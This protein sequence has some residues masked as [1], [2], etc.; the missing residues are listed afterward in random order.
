M[1]S[2]LLWKSVIIVLALCG[3][4]MPCQAEK[5]SAS[6]TQGE[7]QIMTY[8]SNN[9]DAAK[10]S[11][12]KNK[13][14]FVEKRVLK[15]GMTVLVRKTDQVP[16]VSIQ[17]WYHVGS[18]DEKTGERGI[19][20]LIEHMMFKGTEEL[21]ESDINI[22]THR[23]SGSTNAFTS[24]DY[25]GYLFN[26]PTQHWREALPVMADT[27]QHAAFKD[28]HLNSEMKAVIQELKMNRDNYVRSLVSELM[29][30]IFPDHPYHYPVIGYKQDLWSVCSSDLRAFYKKHYLPNNATLIVVGDVDPEEVFTLAE[31]YFGAIKPNENYKKETFYFGQ[32]IISKSITLYRDIKHPTGSML[33][34]V[35][36][37]SSKKTQLLDILSWALGTGKASRLHRKLVDELK[38]ATSVATDYWSLFD[39][40]LFFIIYEPRSA[41]DIPEIERVIGQEL[42]ALHEHGFTDQEFKRALNKAR[43][44]YF[45]MLENVQQQ[46]QEIGLYYLATGD[47]NFAYNYLDEPLEEIKAGVQE[48]VQHY[49]RPV[50]AHK[51][52]VMPLPEQEKSLWETLQEASD[53]QDQEILSAR[54]RLSCVED[55]SYA[56]RIAV[57]QPTPF[58]YPKAQQ[59]VLNNGMKVFYYNNPTTPKIN[60][61]LSFKAK[62]YYDPQEKQ[63]LYE[64]VTRM[65]LEGT[66]KYSAA[67]FAHELESRGMS[68]NI[69]PG[70]LSLSMLS[71]DFEKG[72]ELLHDVLTD[73]IFDQH[74]LE[75]IRQHML[76]DLKQFWDNPR[77]FASQ[78]IRE[79][80][81]PNHPYSKNSLGTQASLEAIT[82]QDLIDFYKKYISPHGAK[83]AIVGDLKNY[84]LKKLV[85]HYLG[86]WQGPVVEDITFPELEVPKAHEVVYPINRDQV[87][88]SFVGLSVDRMHPDFDAL[89]LFDQIFGGGVLGSMSS[90]LFDLREQSGLFYTINGSL[91]AR[92]NEQP[93]MVM[94][95]TLVSLDRL[96]EAE[97]VIKQTID[98]VV[99]TVKNDELIEARNAIVNASVNNFESNE[100]IAAAFLFL[101]RYGLPVDYFDKRAERLA[102]IG[103]DNVINTVK[104]LLSTKK[105]ITFKIGRINQEK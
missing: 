11:E 79:N 56:L 31:Q 4:T 2:I 97:K 45:N 27:M 62:D 19:A 37:V 33:F 20:H 13:K 42:T 88:L 10:Y 64:F 75:K 55:P 63:G 46:A 47:E 26:F 30:A 61:V 40:G 101:D 54:E 58:I 77:S 5:H 86:S 100:G 91:T 7:N 84:D 60:I 98:A 67:Q 32:D 34:V 74:E 78:L 8:T 36:G 53:I 35:P 87:F 24:Y 66:K 65:M 89:L 39:H 68:L 92:A 71:I 22:L 93:G 96:Q 99:D 9:M 85:E 18:K 49:F 41:K 12:K 59:F 104:K 43:M 70:G 1:K 23:L 25:T 29:S 48:I 6:V 38:I 95:Q 82:R 103:K 50:V 21:S 72:L 81:Y 14:R 28:D 44:H 102:K 51:G 17:L 3:Q 94:V 16:K 80:I 57:K 69:H 90:R 76:T 15:N 83:V 52:Y 73:A 105:M